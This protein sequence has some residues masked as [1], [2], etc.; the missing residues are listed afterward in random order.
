L[1]NN[2]Y[3]HHRRLEDASVRLG[4]R[5]RYD[6]PRD[7]VHGIET[8]ADVGRRLCRVSRGGNPGGVGL[9]G[10]E[11]FDDLAPRHRIDLCC[12][13]HKDGD[14]LDAGG[15]GGHIPRQDAVGELAV[16]RDRVDRSDLRQDRADKLPYC[17]RYLSIADCRSKFEARCV[18]ALGPPYQHEAIRLPYVL[19]HTYTPDF[20]DPVAKV[21]IEP[22]GRFRTSADR[23]KL[24]TLAKQHPEYTIRVWFLEPDRNFFGLII[25]N[26]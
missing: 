14:R 5:Q 22:K 19:T 13:A 15:E 1:L 21:I 3:Q 12:I 11:K 9:H 2:R 7:R 8:G 23:T 17:S 20:I 26:K 4:Q 25:N 24:I 6:D 16:R 10:F 18:A